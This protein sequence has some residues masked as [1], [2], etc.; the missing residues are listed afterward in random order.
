MTGHDHYEAIE[1]SGGVA[2]AY[3]M[4]QL[5]VQINEYLKN[6]ALHSEGRRIMREVQIEL[7]DGKSGERVAEFIRDEL[8]NL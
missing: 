3:S 6:P 2:R 7:M 5:L 8:K 1:R 4:E